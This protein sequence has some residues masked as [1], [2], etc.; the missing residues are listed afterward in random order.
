MSSNGSSFVVQMD[1]MVIVSKDENGNTSLKKNPRLRVEPTTTIERFYE[2]MR[3]ITKR[4]NLTVCAD[5]IPIS[6]EGFCSQLYGKK[7]TI[8]YN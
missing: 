3:I 2:D 5:E 6:E 7:I 1:N 4:Q 8:I